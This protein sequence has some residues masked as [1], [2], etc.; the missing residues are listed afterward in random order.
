MNTKSKTRETRRIQ[1]RAT[2]LAH[3]IAQKVCDGQEP[4]KTELYDY[5]KAMD[6]FVRL[7]D[8]QAAED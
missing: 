4:T 3:M 6:K 8:A 7:R 2:Y 5:K 1:S